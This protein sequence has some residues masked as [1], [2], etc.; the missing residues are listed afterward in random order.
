MIILDH[1][2]ALIRALTVGGYNSPNAS[3]EFPLDASWSTSNVINMTF[4]MQ[5]AQSLV[6]IDEVLWMLPIYTRH[7]NVYNLATKRV[8]NNFTYP[9]IAAIFSVRTRTFEQIQ[10]NRT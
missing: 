7:L 4:G 2:F 6:Q 9:G 8:I 3:V 5:F 1:F 10:N